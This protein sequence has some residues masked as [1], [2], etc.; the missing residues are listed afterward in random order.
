MAVS[1]TLPR[2]PAEIDED[3][4]PFLEDVWAGLSCQ[5]K[6]L[7]PK[8]FYDETGSRLF[9]QITEQP[10]YYPTR[11]ELRIL[12]EQRDDI[13][14][15]LPDDA[16]LIEFGAGATKKVRELLRSGKITT[17][18]PVDISGD[19]IA[20]QA[21]DLAQDFPDLSILPVVADFTQGF[22]LPAQVAWQKRVGF[23]PGSTIGNFDPHEASEFLRRAHDILGAH[24]FLILGVDLEKD[25]AL[26]HVAYNDKAGITAQFNLNLLRRINEELGGNF[27]LST[28]A[29]R[30]IYNRE[31]RRV[32]MHL[33]SLKAQSVQIAG[34][35]FNFRM[36]ESIHSESSHKFTVEQMQTLARGAGFVPRA[37]F[38]D[39]DKLFSVH[40]LETQERKSADDE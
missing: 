35:S 12:S 3:C 30:A 9:E 20:A 14:A 24:S 17:Y 36:G 16:A 23:F 2:K 38:T 39:P 13:A 1:K 15:L 4:V 19:F 7:K 37:V 25:P 28:F 21:R 34:R 26:L 5:P 31:K 33:V 11:T 29:H 22:E 6:R 32:E 18:V 10:E 8:Y 27:D 40:V